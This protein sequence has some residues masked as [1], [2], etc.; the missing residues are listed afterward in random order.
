MRALT[1]NFASTINEL[2]FFIL[3]MTSGTITPRLVQSTS[4]HILKIGI[5]AEYTC[6]HCGIEKWQTDNYCRVIVEIMCKQIKS[7]K[8]LSGDIITRAK[9]KLT[10]ASQKL[11]ANKDEHVRNFFSIT[12]KNEE[13]ISI[14]LLFFEKIGL[15]ALLAATR[16][17]LTNRQRVAQPIRLQHLQQ[18]TTKFSLSIGLLPQPR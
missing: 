15:V 11:R 8:F 14:V 13:Y 3:Q 12:S 5:L 7:S 4:V 1:G 17:L 16:F 6:V 18:Y 2:N 9:S 10:I